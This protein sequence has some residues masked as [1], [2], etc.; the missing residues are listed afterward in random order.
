MKENGGW[1]PFRIPSLPTGVT[2]GSD[3]PPRPKTS[4][5][6]PTRPARVES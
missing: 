5:S 6:K 1:E 2:A 3:R 4:I